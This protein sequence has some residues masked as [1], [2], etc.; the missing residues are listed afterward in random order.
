MI[1]FPPFVYIHAVR[2]PVIT[3]NNLTEQNV[4]FG[5]DIDLSFNTTKFV[6][7]TFHWQKDG[8]N[9]SKGHKYRGTTMN[10]LTILNAQYSDEGIYTL[11]VMIEGNLNA[12]LSIHLFVGK[13]FIIWLCLCKSLLYY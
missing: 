6:N 7:A 1:F 13:L 12:S 5:E 10:T 3:S 4:T 9:I 11:V 8:T 2:A